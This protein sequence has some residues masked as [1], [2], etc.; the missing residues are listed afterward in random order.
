MAKLN[1]LTG[2][3]L[4]NWKVLY[5]NGSTPNKA[6]VWHC[7]CLLCGE[8]RDVVGSSLLSGT[9]TKCRRCVPKTSLSKPHRKERIY[10]IYTAMKQ[11]CYNPNA[12]HYADYGGRG[13]TVCDEWKNN[14]DTF[15]EWSFANGYGESLT[16]DRINNNEGYSPDN[17]RWVTL[18][19]QA[20][21]KRNCVYITVDGKTVS[22]LSACDLYGVS[23]GAIKSYRTRHKVSTQDAFNHYRS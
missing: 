19:T 9:S 14:P 12:K 22:L 21:N 2:K 6:A 3:Q 8:E 13:I 7:K 16:I 5:R 17:C 20:K 11:R 4:N 10:H 23:Y 1:D 18:D 15:I